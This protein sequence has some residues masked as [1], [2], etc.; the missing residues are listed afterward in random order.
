MT[1]I[2]INEIALGEL[3]APLIKPF[4]I[5]LWAFVFFMIADLVIREIE[6]YKKREL[7]K[8]NKIIAKQI[9]QK[10]ELQFENEPEKW[11]EWKTNNKEICNLNEYGY[12]KTYY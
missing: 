11:E 3:I 9:Y 12:M 2:T 7:N 6:S 10:R 1:I 8:K 4:L 5:M